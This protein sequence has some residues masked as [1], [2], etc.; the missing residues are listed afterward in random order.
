MSVGVFAEGQGLTC[1]SESHAA[2]A[3]KVPAPECHS[4]ALYR[5]EVVA[6]IGGRR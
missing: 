3:W 6:R 4:G 2:V 1:V 5:E